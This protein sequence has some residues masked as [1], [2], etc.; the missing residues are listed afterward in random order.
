MLKVWVNLNG[1]FDKSLVN[2]VVNNGG[3]FFYSGF[4]IEN[5]K[6][7]FEVIILIR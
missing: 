5:S 6:K 4:D 3:I 7:L 1:V 2:M